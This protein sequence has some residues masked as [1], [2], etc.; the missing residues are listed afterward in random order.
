MISALQAGSQMSFGAKR[1]ISD[2]FSSDPSQD[3]GTEMFRFA[4]QDS[5][6]YTMSSA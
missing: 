3:K 4:Q 2:Q 1:R 5:A 6:I